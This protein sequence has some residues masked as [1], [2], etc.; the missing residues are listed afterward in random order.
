MGRR[1]RTSTS[2]YHVRHTALP[3]P[4]GEARAQAA[5][6]PRVLPGARSHPAAVGAVAGRG[7]SPADRFAVLSKT[8]HAL[9]DGISGRR[10]R[11]GPVRLLAGSDAG[12]PARARVDRRARS[13]AARSCW[14]TPLVERG[15]RPGRDGARRAR[16]AARPSGRGQAGRRSA[17]GR[18]RDGLDG[19][20]GRAA[21]PVQRADRS[22]PPVHLGPRRPGR[23]QGDQERARR[24]RQRRRAGGRRRRARAL[25]A[26]PRPRPPTTSCSRRWSRC[27]SAPTSSAARSATRSP[28]C[29]R[30][31]R[32]ASTDPVERLLEISRAMDG[33]KESG[34][35]VGAQVL[36]DLSG[37]APPTIMA[38]AARLQARQ[39]LFNLVVTNVPGTAVSRSTCWAASSRRSTRWCRWPRTPRWGSRS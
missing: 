23:V 15:D 5:G 31:S 39:R 13:R 7:R 14:P 33:V 20:S 32:S 1:S 28:R 11:H 30:R 38:Q 35:A 22:A 9:V 3:R 8:H 21:E 18:R 36:T 17:R 26:P 6:R 27:R 37:F 12:R 34:Q 29:G 4:G 25:H 16:D 10:H 24:H 2:R 19:A